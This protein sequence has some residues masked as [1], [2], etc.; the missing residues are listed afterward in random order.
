MVKCVTV[1]WVCAGSHMPRRISR[2]AKYLSVSGQFSQFARGELLAFWFGQPGPHFRLLFGGVE[3]ND[4]FFFVA[5]EIEVCQDGEELAFGVEACDVGAKGGE[6]GFVGAGLERQERRAEQVGDLTVGVPCDG[7][8]LD[9]SDERVEVASATGMAAR[10]GEDVEAGEGHVFGG[11]EGVEI[12]DCGIDG[13]PH[14]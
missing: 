7:V 14:R 12:E 11:Q 5:A 10:A 2:E 4:S 1:S 3:S 8:W 6:G 13:F 9:H